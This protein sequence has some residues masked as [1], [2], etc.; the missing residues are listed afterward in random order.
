[1]LRHVAKD[2]ADDYANKDL[3]HADLSN[4]LFDGA[5]QY[6]TEPCDDQDT[7]SWGAC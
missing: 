4:R 6:L 3:R 5:N 1:M 7:S 2:R